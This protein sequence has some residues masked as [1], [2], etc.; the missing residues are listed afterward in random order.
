MHLIC[1]YKFFGEYIIEDNIKGIKVEEIKEKVYADYNR[2]TPKIIEKYDLEIPEEIKDI[3]SG[4]SKGKLE[5]LNEQ[6][7]YEFIEDMSKIDIE[8]YKNE[9]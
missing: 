8:N 4:V 7:V 5:I 2:I 3:I 1:D 6:K 9:E